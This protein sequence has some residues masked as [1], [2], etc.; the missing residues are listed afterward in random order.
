MSLLI[1]CARFAMFLDIG[2]VI[3]NKRRILQNH[4]PITFAT[5]AKFL[6]I[7]YPPVQLDLNLVTPH[8]PLLLRDIFAKYA[9]FRD[10]GSKTVP[11]ASSY[12]IDR[13]VGFA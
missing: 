12:P 1:M 13:I 5:C 6:V 11:N 4:L 10:T 8:R 2:S 9:K 3:V 7:L